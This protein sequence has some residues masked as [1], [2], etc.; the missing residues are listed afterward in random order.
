MQSHVW[1]DGIRHLGHGRWVI[2]ITDGEARKNLLP[3]EKL[4]SLASTNQKMLQPW[5]IDRGLRPVKFTSV[6]TNFADWRIAESDIVDSIVANSSTP[7]ENRHMVFEFPM[8]SN[9]VLIPAGIIMAKLFKPLQLATKYLLTPHGLESFCVPNLDIMDPGVIF[10][11][12]GLNERKSVRGENSR[13]LSWLWCFPSARETW[14]SVFEFANRG[15][16]GLTLPSAKIIISGSGL[17]SGDYVIATHITIRQLEIL[18]EP[19]SFAPE[20]A[21]KLIIS[22]AAPQAEAPLP[23][24]LTRPLNDLEWAHLKQIFE[25]YGGHKMRRTPTRIIVDR[26]HHKLSTGAP[27]R[28]LAFAG[29]TWMNLQFHLGKWIKNGM[30]AAANSKLE[31]LGAIS[32]A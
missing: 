17:V 32:R 20:H 29:S 1:V 14:N 7:T 25:P 5:H 15:I 24:Y 19:F 26:L 30:W 28:S 11:S 16:L 31:Q 2:E 27:W 12:K 4:N 21:R 9:T 10:S 18:E 6:E 22:R 13:L 23:G 8:N 3:A